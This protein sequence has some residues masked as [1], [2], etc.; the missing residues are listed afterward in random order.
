MLGNRPM[1]GHTAL[2][3]SIGVRVPVPQYPRLTFMIKVKTIQYMS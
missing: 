2:D 3:R 1:A